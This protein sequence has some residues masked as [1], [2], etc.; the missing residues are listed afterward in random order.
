[1]K[2]Q[3]DSMNKE[4]QSVHDFWN[5]ASCGESLYL[6]SVT[7]DGFEA[8]A[9]RRYEL[10]PFILQFAQFE[11]SKGKKV[12]EIGVGLGADHQ[13]F[14][15]SGA[16]LFGID[17]TERAIDHTR[18]RLDAFALHSTLN[19]GDAE[20]LGFA[21]GTFDLVYSW[22]VL[23]HSPN[24]AKAISE[25]YRVLKRGGSAK[26]MI[27]YKWSMIGLMLW[28]RYGLLRMRPW[29]SLAQIYSRHLE[30]P[31]TK[32]YSIR[33]ARKL[34]EQFSAVRIQTVL[35]HGDLLTSDA[36]QRHQGAALSLARIFWPST[37]IRF[38]LPNSGLF[39]LIQATK[40]L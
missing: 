9:K 39:M 20:Q 35:T 10:E 32:A 13:S 14:A 28:M 40:K 15:E 16:D 34:F 30:S 37:L 21:D 12:L 25:V 18:N 11:E 5:Q 38:I 29:T 24:T 7:R 27:Y 23:H 26:I 17:L 33:E 22:G 4:K 36:G 1:M 2:N 19:V 8:Q 6:E 3:M 31:G